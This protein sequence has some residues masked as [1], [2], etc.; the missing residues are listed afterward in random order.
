[1]DNVTTIH[2]NIMLQ[3]GIPKNQKTM[4]KNQKTENRK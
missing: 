4:N 1:V 2:N 3:I